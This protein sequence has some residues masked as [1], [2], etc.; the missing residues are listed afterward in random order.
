M[1]SPRHSLGSLSGMLDRLAA[2][3][4]PGTHVPAATLPDNAGY[5]NRFEIKSESSDR[6]YVIAQS[7]TG[8]WWSCSC[9]GWISRKKCKHLTTLGLPGGH[10]PFEPKAP[11]A[12][13]PTR[14][15]T[16]ARKTFAEIDASRKRYD[17]EKEGLGDP[18]A[19]IAKFGARMG[20]DEAVSVVRALSET[21]RRIM[22]LDGHVTWNEVRAAYRVHMTRIPESDVEGR[23][24]IN[25]AYAVLARELG[26]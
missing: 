25:A 23:R 1:A 15:D 2:T 13:A 10:Q 26:H 22:G 7:K 9:S 21:P 3:H 6:I 8:R 19:W 18:D 20:F 16:M 4:A 17:V 11:R 14:E 5:T 24:S 12:A